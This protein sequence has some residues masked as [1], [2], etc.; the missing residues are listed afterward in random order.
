[1]MALSALLL[2]A[3]ALPV[4]PSPTADLVVCKI[5]VRDC[6]FQDTRQKETQC[7]N[8]IWDYP[9]PQTMDGFMSLSTIFAATMA[10][11]IGANDVANS[12]ATSVGS[13]AISVGYAVMLCGLFEWGGATALGHGVSMTLQKGVTTLEE[14]KCWACGFCN[15]QVTLAMG[16][17]LCSLI[18]A[19]F[20]LLV[21]S[22]LAIPVSTTHALVGGMIGMTLVAVGGEHCLNWSFKKGMGGIAFGWVLFPFVSM[23]IASIAYYLSKRFVIKSPNPKGRALVMIPCLYG[24]STFFTIM[25]I[26]FSN[27]SVKKATALYTKLIVSFGVGGLVAA[28]AYFGLYDKIV[29]AFPSN[30]GETHL[31]LYDP[32]KEDLQMTSVGDSNLS[33]KK[34]L[35]APKQSQA[36]A[37]AQDTAVKC[38]ECR[39]AEEGSMGILATADPVAAAGE[40]GSWIIKDATTPDEVDAIFVFRYI[41]VFNACLESFA[42]GSNDTANST[43]PFAV[44]YN[45]YTKGKDQCE[46]GQEHIWIVSVAGLFVALGVMTFGYRVMRTIGERITII[47]FHKGFW[48]EFG[49]TT[50][51]MLATATKFPVS[52]T[53]C[54][55]GAVIG[56][57]MIT[58]GQG[59][60]EVAWWLLFK[61]C[62][63]WIMTFPLAGFL[64]AV[65]MLAIK[66]AIIKDTLTV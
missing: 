50:A 37:R 57:G 27:G 39:K 20:F 30:V 44:V 40:A 26:F 62:G 2:G 53:H 33:A 5:G 58:K 14:P 9:D 55:V 28:V 66:G 52:T 10:F 13:R 56:V 35:Q 45:F 12:W 11:G 21:V 24:F 23:A 42:H 51:T 31:Y 17:F 54:Q 49:S 6:E 65:C 60:G 8:H 32:K 22:R 47:D 41:L 1:M 18:G 29:A 34:S 15:S 61:I 38:E 7:A 3:Y 16:G 36:G 64:S 4:T 25:M 63:T 43:G 59:V 46:I 19:S 48:I